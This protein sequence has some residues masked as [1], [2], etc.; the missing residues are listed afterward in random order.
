MTVFLVTGGAGF[1]GS[2]L[3]DAIVQRGDQ[4]RVLD[5]F[6]TGDRANLQQAPSSDIIEGDVRDLSVVRHAMR[7]V[8]FVLHLAAR[9]S[10]SESISDPTGTHAV[11]VDGTFNILDTAR[12]LGVRRVVFSS[13][14]AVYG[15]NPDQ[16]L[17]E[18]AAT[19]PL[20]PYAASKL[21]GEVYCQTFSRTYNLP[22][23]CLRY[24]NIYGPRQNPAGDYAAVIPK[25]GQRIASGQ[26]PLIY[27]DGL[28]TRDFVHVRDVVRAN[29]LAC[30][31]PA[32]VGQVFNIASG[33]G[34]SLLD[35]IG[36]FSQLRGQSIEPQ[37][38][39]ERPGDIK[40]SCGDGGRIAAA[41][42]FYP[43]M[44]LQEGLQN[45]NGQ[46]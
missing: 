26:P 42:G 40:H 9:V 12:E 13:S 44:T 15:D 34:L 35:L 14:C 21:I 23:V 43:Q 4:V 10:V 22:T 31:S 36:A 20:S 29:L 11:N 45:L 46:F 25:F 32:A 3:V 38:L 7:G 27:G 17:S 39:P 30:D 2:H 6:S 16:P 33:H 28:Q 18:N 5:N 24:F 19:Q 8:D 37:H 1:I 41:L